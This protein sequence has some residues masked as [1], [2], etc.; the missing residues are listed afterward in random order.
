MRFKKAMLPLLGLSALSAISLASCN[1]NTTSQAESSISQS[2]EN[3]NKNLTEI[4]CNSYH[5]STK[6]MLGEDFNY[7]GLTVTAIYSD[8]TDKMLSNGEFIVDARNFKKNEQGTYTIFVIYVEGTFRATTKYDVTVSSIAEATQPHLLGI[9]ATL[10]K[11]TY[12]LGENF[13]ETGL[14]VVAHYSDDTEKEIEA[15]KYTIDK[16]GLAM[17]QLGTSMLKLAYSESY[18]QGDKTETKNVETFIFINVEASLSSI[19]FVSGTLYVTQD[20]VGPDGTYGTMDTSDWVIEATFVDKN[21]K[22]IVVTVSPSDITLKGLNTGASG[23]QEVTISYFAY[24]S[25]K[26]TKVTVHV[27]AIAQA[28]YTFNASNIDDSLAGQTLKEEYKFDETIS[29]GNKCQVK[30]EKTD[31][32]AGK[33]FGDLLFTKRVQTNGMGKPNDSNYIKVTLTSD[34][35]VAII[36]RSSGDAKP[37]TEAG[38]YDENKNAKSETYAYT[39]SISKY[40]YELKAGTYYFYDVTYAVQVYGIQIWYK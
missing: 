6:F 39:T 32:S 19:K 3:T 25:T 38:F 23:D 22:K 7:N 5:A 18:T 8:H 37:V 14:K 29:F 13:D 35:T 21:W 30:S 4:V 34:A 2:Q 16:T 15:G 31:S 10:P 28:D 9:E 12:K 36:G 20:T 24:G 17:D 33:T 40:K 1:S 11:T 26:T 27:D